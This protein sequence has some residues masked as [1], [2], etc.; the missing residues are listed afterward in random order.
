MRLPRVSHPASFAFCFEKELVLD[1]RGSGSPLP[2]AG[3]VFAQN[4]LKFGVG[5]Q[6]EGKDY[7]GFAV[8]VPGQRVV[9]GVGADVLRVG[10]ILD[11]QAPERDRISRELGGGLYLQLDRQAGFFALVLGAED[12]DLRQFEGVDDAAFGS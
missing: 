9:P 4:D 1:G 3:L 7:M 8:G 5:L 10:A 2:T 11:G 6:I 12:G